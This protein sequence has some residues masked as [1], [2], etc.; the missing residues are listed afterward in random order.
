MLGRTRN[1]LGFLFAF[2]M[3]AW[4]ASP[5]QACSVPVFRYALERWRNDPYEVFIYHRGELSAADKALAKQ[6]TEEGL[7]GKKYAN[8]Q[9]TDV[10]LD[11]LDPQKEDDAFLLRHWEHQKSELLPWMVVRYPMPTRIPVDMWKGPLSQ[12]SIETLIDSPLRREIARRLL[13]GETGVWLMLEMG[14]KK[15]DDAAFATLQKELKVLE[16]QIKLPEIDEADIA[17]GLVMIDPAELKVKFSTLRLSRDNAAE[18][19][20]VEMLL[21]TEEDLREFKEPMIFPMFGRGR[22]LYALIGDGINAD[23]LAQAGADLTGPCT[24]TIKEQNPGTDMV[25]AVDWDT[26][27]EPSTEI[28]KELPPLAGLSGFGVPTDSESTT[29]DE[30]TSSTNEPEVAVASKEAPSVK[31]SSSVPSTS[32]AAG[33][34]SLMRNVLIAVVLAF[35]AVVAGSV[36]LGRKMG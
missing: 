8:I 29:K 10:D 18:K 14:D 30:N 7:A 26:L 3:A 31:V 19:M 9:L 32:S 35:A 22:A 1:C 6:L 21:G 25:M 36:A 20:F 12:K 27:V 13:K 34:S 28:D 16:T 15:K 5:L 24:C 23:T 2:G 11:K 17:Q 4:M 33:S